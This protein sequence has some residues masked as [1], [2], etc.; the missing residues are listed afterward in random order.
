MARE[1]DIYL[2]STVSQQ[3]TDFSHSFTCFG[4][5]VGKRAHS[6]FHQG[7]KV[8]MLE[9]PENVNFGCF[10]INVSDTINVWNTLEFYE[11]KEVFSGINY[12]MRDNELVGN[13][14]LSI[15]L[16]FALFCSCHIF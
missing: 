5:V 16:N 4:M 8:V 10:L 1:G 15:Q 13:V 12:I 14:K 3:H 2:F 6:N 7:F 9:K 11:K